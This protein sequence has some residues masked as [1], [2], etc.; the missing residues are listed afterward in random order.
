MLHPSSGTVDEF[1]SGSNMVSEG[2]EVLI[3]DV[4]FFQ[5]R[6]VIPA[7]LACITFNKE[8][9]VKCGAS[10]FNAFTWILR[11]PPHEFYNC[12]SP[13]T[14]YASDSL[15]NAFTSNGDGNV[16]SGRRPTIAVAGCR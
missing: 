5:T 2:S 11:H 3:F 15:H 8:T 12:T 10:I 6:A 4:C 16:F 9:P 1:G 14:A 13:L 7:K